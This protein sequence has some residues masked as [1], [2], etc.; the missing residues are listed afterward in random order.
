MH[1]K[2]DA[3]DI[4]SRDLSTDPRRITLTQAELRR[5]VFVPI[6]GGRVYRGEYTLDGDK[7]TTVSWWE[8]KSN[9][10][11]L[12]T[13]RKAEDPLHVMVYKRVRN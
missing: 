3:V 8:P 4:I 10:P 11:P 2:S 7:L 9:F 6:A 13:H 12:P 1:V 5:G